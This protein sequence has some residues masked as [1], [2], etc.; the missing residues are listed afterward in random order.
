MINLI[1][2]VEKSNKPLWLAAGLFLLGGVAVGDYITGAELSFS[3]FYLLPIALISLT[4]SGTAGIAI[5]FLSAAIWLFLEVMTTT[6]TN[7]YVYL[8]NAIIR[9]GFFLLPALLLKVIEQEKYHA[10][11]DFLTGAV[12]RFYFNELMGREIDRSCRYHHP[13]TIAFMDLDNFKT[14]NDTFGHSFGDDLLRTIAQNMKK[15]LRKTDSIA[16]VGGDE[17]VI[18]LPETNSDSAQHAI[19][20]L[21]RKLTDELQSKKWPVTF[22]VGVLTL[23]APTIS[24]DKIFG[25][26]DRM[27]Y[28]V[29]NSGKNDIK[30]A[31]HTN[32]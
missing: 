32:D 24:T 12:N 23:T 18:L 27:M 14:I 31:T 17:F 11:T 6:A 13:F 2:S 30:F 29:K 15:N 21:F 20:N 5:A 26:V 22:S 8:W 9:L 7:T 10:R 28:S 25:I 16:R 1:P 4:F 3:L 19:R